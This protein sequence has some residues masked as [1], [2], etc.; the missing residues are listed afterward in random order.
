MKTSVSSYSFQRKYGAGFTIFDAIAYTKEIGYDSIELVTL[1]PPDGED[2]AG[3]AR[4]VKAA[5]DGAGLDVCA[6]AVS[7]DFLN[8]SDGDMKDET[9]RIKGCVDIAAI[10]GAPKMRHD[11]TWGSAPGKQIGAASYRDAIRHIAPAIRAVTEYAQDKGIRTMSENH[12]Y[13]MQESARMEE[14]V[15]AVAHANYGILVDVGNFL[16]ADEDPVIAVSRLAPVAAHVHAKDFLFK[17]GSAPKPDE[18]WFATRGG[19]YLRG[20]VVGHGVVPVA[21][22]LRILRGAGYNDTISLEFEGVE[23][24]LRAIK[25]GY[26]F[27]KRFVCEV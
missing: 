17:P 24:P 22:C 12:G 7:A 10:L 11:A 14:L 9:E 16:C 20:T 18:E 6:Y 2:A 15:W 25:L 3:F 19:N 21:Q 5:C 8:P 1:V 4:R 23:E 13:F 26:D 27:L